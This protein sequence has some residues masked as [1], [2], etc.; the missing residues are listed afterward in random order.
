MCEYCHSYPH[1]HGCPNEPDP[2]TVYNCK[3]CGGDIREG[4][5]YWEI[6]D[7]VY[8]E[9]CFYDGIAAFC[10]EHADVK[11]HAEDE[12]ASEEV[13]GKCAACGDDV[14]E[15]EEYYE[16]DGNLYHAECFLDKANELFS[17]DIVRC[18][19]EADEYW[20]EDDD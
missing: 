18:T 12:N 15:W 10:R 16:Y 13:I 9:D 20:P 17:D 4:D 19:A 8:C 14:L 6:G 5:E 1:L 3:H 7:E 2:E 11:Y